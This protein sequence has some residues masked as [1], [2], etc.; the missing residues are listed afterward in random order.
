MKDIGSV[1]LPRT[2]LNGLS[3]GLGISWECS[4]GDAS[5]NDV[6]EFGIVVDEE[7]IA[8]GLNYCFADN[9]K[10][11]GVEL[12]FL[13]V[14]ATVAHLTLKSLSSACLFYELRVLIHGIYSGVG[15]A[16]IRQWYRKYLSIV[17][18]D[19]AV[20]WNDGRHHMKRSA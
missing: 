10:Q 3:E 17:S 20:I 9:V 2:S 15:G 13:F 11:S 18:R 7:E 4:G 12:S 5:S 6:K 1:S 8:C 16:G 19:L 14:C